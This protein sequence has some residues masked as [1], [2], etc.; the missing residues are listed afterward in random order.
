[1]ALFSTNATASPLG[2]LSTILRMIAALWSAR[3]QQPTSE[4]TLAASARREAA[5]ARVDKLLR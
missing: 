5:R 4:H 3:P 2:S 1:M